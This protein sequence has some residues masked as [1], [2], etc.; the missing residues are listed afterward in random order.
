MSK[1]KELRRVPNKMKIALLFKLPLLD[2]SLENA[3][4]NSLLQRFHAKIRSR[5]CGTCVDRNE[6]QLIPQN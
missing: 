4:N 5:D 3:L 6:F 1:I 2:K